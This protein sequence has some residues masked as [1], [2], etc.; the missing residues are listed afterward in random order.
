MATSIGSEYLAFSVGTGEFCIDILGVREIRGYNGVTKLPSSPPDIPG[1]IDLRGV[2]VPLVD[3]RIRFGIDAPTYDST[4]IVI[5]LSIEGRLTGIVVDGVSEVFR[6]LE[7]DIKEPPGIQGTGNL[8]ITGI[9]T[10][11][12]RMVVVLNIAGMLAMTAGE[13]DA[14][15]TAAQGSR[16]LAASA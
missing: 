13:L 8:A 1:V 12:Q 10:I 3:L 9:A 15:A 4:T 11:E 2:I 7:S 5:V 16:E 6:A 14:L